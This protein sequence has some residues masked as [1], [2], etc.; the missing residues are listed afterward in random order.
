MKTS[1]SNLTLEL[2]VTFQL[3]QASYSRFSFLAT[4]IWMKML[5]E[6][7]DKFG[8]TIK[9]ARGTLAFPWHGDIFLM[10]VLMER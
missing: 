3:L 6:K 1:Y 5:W 8:V 2:G 4:H 9:T 7:L 10:L